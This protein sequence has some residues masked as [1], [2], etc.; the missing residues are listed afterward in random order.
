MSITFGRTPGQ[1]HT[2]SFLMIIIKN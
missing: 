2:F 1:T